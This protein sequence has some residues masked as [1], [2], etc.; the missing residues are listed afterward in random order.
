MRFSIGAEQ[1]KAKE[2]H[3]I[4]AQIKTARDNGDTYELGELKDKREQAQA[5]YWN[6]R[7]GRE[8]MLERYSAHKEEQTQAAFQ[9]QIQ[10][11]QTEIPNLI[12]DF[13]D[14]VASSIRDFALAE[15]INESLLD[16][17]VDPVVVK[18]IDDY[19]RLKSGVSKGTAKRKAAPVKKA[20]PTKKAPAASKKRADAEKMTKA[21]AFKDGASVDDQM[22]FLRNHAS[23]SLSNL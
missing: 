16:G 21:R 15:G 12:P 23:K 11:F 20:V 7:K 18:F 22:A 8:D 9:E 1:A 19:R 6:A 2:Y 5:A 4:E 14:K 13:D 3:D 10:H 17:V